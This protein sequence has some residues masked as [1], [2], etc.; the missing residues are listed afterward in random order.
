TFTGGAD[1]GA[2]AMGGILSLAHSGLR[3][4]SI[5]GL[6]PLAMAGGGVVRQPSLALIGENLGHHEAVWP[7]P[8][9]PSIP[10]LFTQKPQMQGADRP[11]VIQLHQ[12]FSGAIDPRTLRT[13]HSEIIGVVAKDVSTDGPLRRVIVQHAR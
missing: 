11:I 6:Q 5:A 12:D 8:A 13:P 2:F 3:L 4:R 7:L 9:N 1:T 10:V